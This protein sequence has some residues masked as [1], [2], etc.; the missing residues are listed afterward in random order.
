MQKFGKLAVVAWVLLCAVAGFAADKSLKLASPISLN[1]QQLTAGEYQVKY[2]VNGSTA[3]VHFLKNNKEV[4]TANA[5]VVERATAPR[6]DSVITSSST[7]GAPTLIELQF[8]GQKS[9]IHFGADSAA[10]K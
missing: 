9:A 6:N 1:G 7:A 4:A 3:E 8:A 5:Q 10:G 2:Q